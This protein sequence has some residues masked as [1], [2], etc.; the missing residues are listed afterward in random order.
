MHLVLLLCFQ[1]LAKGRSVIT[2]KY[3]FHMK[4]SSSPHEN[5]SDVHPIS[6]SGC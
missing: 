1:I 6:D 4:E 2:C 5:W 3:Y